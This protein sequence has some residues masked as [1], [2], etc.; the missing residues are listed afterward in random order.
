M[1]DDLACPFPG[2]D[3]FLESQYWRDF[4]S[5]FITDIRDAL[6]GQLPYDY[7]VTVE[8]RVLLHSGGEE[9]E[10]RSLIADGAVRQK[11]EVEPAP[12]GGAAVAEPIASSGTSYSLMTLPD[13]DGHTQPYVEVRDSL[14]NQLVTVIELLSPANKI[15]DGRDEYLAK[16]NALIH[17]SIHLVELDLLR[18][19]RRLPMTTPLPPSDFYAIVSDSGQR[20]EAAVHH[21]SLPDDL[22]TVQVPLRS[23][24]KYATLQLGRMFRDRHARSGYRHTLDY[25]RPLTPRLPS[26]HAAWVADRLAAAGLPR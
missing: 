23:F 24:R 2:V 21:W 10:E 17:S 18:G 11:P 15:G 22:P 8:E 6:R 12:G 9:P 26:N 14:T 3:P 19:G 20:P 25:G 1:P 7:V 5:T 13:L 4:H 16:R